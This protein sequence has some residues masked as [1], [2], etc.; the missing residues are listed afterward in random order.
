MISRHQVGPVVLGTP[1]Q[2]V[3]QRITDRELIDLG[4]E[5]H[6]SPALALT[7]PGLRQRGGVIAEL[8]PRDSYLAVWRISVTDPTVRTAKGI[9]VGSTVDEVR[10]AYE[11]NSVGYGEGAFIVRVDELAASF[12]LE[13]GEPGWR[14]QSSVPGHLKVIS[15]LLTQ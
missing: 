11:I 2:I 4:L 12:V 9:G 5:G 15:V 1:A 10:A 8:V 3:Y 14:E 13:S 6:L 7:L